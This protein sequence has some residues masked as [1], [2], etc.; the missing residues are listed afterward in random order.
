MIEPREP[1]HAVRAPV[2]DSVVHAG[3]VVSSRFASG[4]G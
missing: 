2:D 3:E 4:A 1:S